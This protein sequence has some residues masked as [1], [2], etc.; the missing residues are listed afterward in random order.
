[1]P[2]GTCFFVLLTFILFTNFRTYGV[3]LRPGQISPRDIRSPVTRVIV[4]E[5]RTQELKRQAAQRVKNVYQEDTEALTRASGDIDTFFGQVTDL[6]NPV[7]VTQTRKVEELTSLLQGVVAE[8]NLK[9]V[10]PKQLATYILNA[11]DDDLERIRQ[12]SHKILADVMDKPITEDALPS[13]YQQAFEQARSLQFA[14]EAEQI[15][16]IAVCQAVR[17]NMIFDAEATQKR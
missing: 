4:D 2:S 11:G 17:P 12:Q 5:N 3:Q 8:R 15:I 1:M 14:S 9:Q 13:V 6:R 7:E 10:N 16:A